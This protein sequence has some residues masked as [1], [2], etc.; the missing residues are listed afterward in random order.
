VRRRNEELTVYAKGLTY[1]ISLF[2][3]QLAQACYLLQS[4]I[5][6]PIMI[7]PLRA[8]RKPTPQPSSA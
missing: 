5:K 2:G 8:P 3:E 6:M 7:K 4:S 1:S